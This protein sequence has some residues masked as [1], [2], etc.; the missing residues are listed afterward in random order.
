[1]NSRSSVV[2]SGRG[3]GLADA[4]AFRSTARVFVDQA[5]RMEPGI[6]GGPSFVLM[7]EAA[8]GRAFADARGQHEAVCAFLDCL[9][10][11]AGQGTTP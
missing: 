8:D 2:V 7:K 1:M 11:A 10:R 5:G 4:E 9:K 6:A 3:F